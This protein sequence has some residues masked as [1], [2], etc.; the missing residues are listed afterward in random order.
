FFDHF[1]A[2]IRAGLAAAGPIDG[3]YNSEPG[4]AS[5]T[6]D[7]DPDGTLF[8]TVRGIVG[9]NTPVVATLDLHANV[10]GRMVEEADLLIA[11]LTNPHVDQRERGQEAAMAMRELLSGTRTA[12]A[13]VKLPLM[14]PTVTLLTNEGPG[15]RPYG[16]LIRRGQA[17]I[18]A[19]VMNVS[20]LAGFYLTDS[21][22]AGMSVIVTTRG[23]AAR[24]QQLAAELARSAW[25]DRAR[26]V[27][28]LITV[29]EATRRMLAA[30]RD[31]SLPAL[32]FADTADNPG[33]G[34]RGNT[35]DILRAFMEAGIRG[36]AFGIH[37]DAPLA[38]EAHRRGA[39]SRFTAR[40]NSEER[41]SLSKKLEAEVEVVKV[42]D[43]V[44][45]G[46]RTATRARTL[47]LGPSARLRIGGEGGI[48]V[49]VISIR[50]Q[51]TDPVILEHFGIDVAK[52]R[53]VVVKSRGH[54]RAAFGEFFRDD[55]I[56][57]IDAPGLATQNLRNL[58]YRNV[59]RPIYP[60]DPDTPWQA[61][62]TT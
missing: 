59:P 27:P 56:L 38:E 36:V 62:P 34:G 5:A 23:D 10:S 11:F 44:L 58:P 1:L 37:N 30:S 4:A 49:V 6:E 55:Q 39:G 19:T 29:E 33:G 47:V 18:D 17:A 20:V 15:P 40:F 61:P 14:P 43:G 12:K 35:T 52:L 45:I 60:L 13:F 57:E 32:C 24:A 42:S 54:F 2:R 31:P 3:V 51:I 22:K 21:P 25:E 8:A 41:D 50:Q 28:S 16:D 9:A 26:Y 48:D 46:R 53:G 7:P